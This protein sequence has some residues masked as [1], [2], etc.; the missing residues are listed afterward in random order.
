MFKAV[1]KE[2]GVV[3][4][5]YACNGFM[6][7]IYDGAEMSWRWVEMNNFVPYFGGDQQ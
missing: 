5:I 7:L 4:T 3:Y 1:H 6:F 2:T